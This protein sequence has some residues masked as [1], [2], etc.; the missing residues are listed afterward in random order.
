MDPYQVKSSFFYTMGIF[1]IFPWNTFLNLNA[2]FEESFQNPNI[3]QYY[4]FCFFFFA[5]LSMKLSIEVDKRFDIFT[6]STNLFFVVLVSFN[7]I[8]FIC[9]YLPINGF[10]YAIFIFMVCLLSTSHF[11]YDVSLLESRNR[12]CRS[13]QRE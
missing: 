6:S 11:I 2:Y 10:K 4:T 5:L 9:E 13:V 1:S 3:S 12:T 7:L 8:Y